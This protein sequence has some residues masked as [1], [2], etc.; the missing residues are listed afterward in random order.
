MEVGSRNLPRIETVVNVHPSVKAIRHGAFH[1]CG[2][3]TNV[4]LG[5]GWEE[6]GELVFDGCASL[7][8]IRIPR[9]VK[10]IKG[11]AFA[12]CSNLTRVI[13]GEGL[14]EIGEEAF[15]DCTSLNEIRIPHAVKVIKGG[16]MRRFGYRSRHADY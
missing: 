7:H 3:L 13:L 16:A 12:R 15:R 5:E 1:G 10:V 11:G 9:A 14:E 4:I 6:I 2:E 8:D